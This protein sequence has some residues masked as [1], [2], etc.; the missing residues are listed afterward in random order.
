[1]HALLGFAVLVWNWVATEEA[2]GSAAHVADMRAELG[3][4]RIP[5]D[6]LAWCDRLVARKRKRFEGDLR[7]VGT[8]RVDRLRDRFSIQMGTRVPMPFTRS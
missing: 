3:G 4:G 1:M 5:A 6:I 7:L 8:W 2:D